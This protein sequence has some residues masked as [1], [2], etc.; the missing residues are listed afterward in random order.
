MNSGSGEPQHEPH[1]WPWRTGLIGGGG[2]FAFGLYGLLRNATQTI[3][4]DWAKWIAGALVL[5]DALL[6]PAV[7]LVGALVTRLAPPALRSG[8]QGTLA[9]CGVVALMSVPVVMAAGRRADNPSLLPHDY[10]QNLAI[11]LAVILAGG[12][13]LTISRAARA[14][15]RPRAPTPGRS[16]S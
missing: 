3:P 8:L 14:G 9:V 4:A 11:V 1:G 15:R 2:M 16:N 10:G 5:H 6:V 7:L 12:T 13:V